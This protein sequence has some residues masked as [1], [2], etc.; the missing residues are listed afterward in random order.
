[1]K[2]HEYQQ[3]FKKLVSNEKVLELKNMQRMILKNFVDE[4]VENGIITK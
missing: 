4:L 3:E 2:L 1:M